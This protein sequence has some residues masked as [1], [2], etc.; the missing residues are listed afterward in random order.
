MTHGV[1]TTAWILLTRLVI[2]IGKV[3][4]KWLGWGGNEIRLESVEMVLIE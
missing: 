1:A 2:A 4:W 3:E